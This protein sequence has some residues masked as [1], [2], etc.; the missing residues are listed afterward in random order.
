MK[1]VLRDKDKYI[2][3]FDKGEDLLESLKTFCREENIRAGYFSGI[4]ASA[5]VVLLHYDVSTKKYSEKIFQEKMEIVNLS[6]NVSW[7]ADKTYLHAHGVFS[8]P[9]MESRAGHVKKLII[10]AT[11]EIS[12]QKLEGEIG[13]EFSADIGLNLLK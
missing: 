8:N 13:R 11:G 6:G 2:L 9:E 1:L 3:R 4:G 12:L 7:F 5:E 10:A